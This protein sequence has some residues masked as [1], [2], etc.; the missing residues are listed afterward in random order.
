MEYGAGAR[1]GYAA[2][3]MKTL[4]YAITTA[5]FL[6]TAGPAWAVTSFLKATVTGTVQ[7]QILL[8]PNDGRIQT[9]PLNNK[10]IF[11]EFQVSPQDY[12]LA[13]DASGNSGALVLVPKHTAAMLPTITVVELG[14]TSAEA[15]DTKVRVIKLTTNLGPSTATNLFKNVAGQLSGTVHFTGTIQTPVFSKFIFAV[16]ASGTNSTGSG[17]AVLKFKITTQGAFVPQ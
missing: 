2:G 12:E 10:R 5:L 7:T 4:L 15:I 8:S 16:A 17:G 3:T 6:A 13:V 1:A 14:N 9:V 11:Q